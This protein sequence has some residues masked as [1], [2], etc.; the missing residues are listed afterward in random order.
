MI[1]SFS[2]SCTVLWYISYLFSILFCV[3][4]VSI[5]SFIN[6]F[7]H[8][9]L[10]LCSCTLASVSVAVFHFSCM[11]L[12][13]NLRLFLL[14]VSVAVYHFIVY[15]FVLQSSFDFCDCF[16]LITISCY[17]VCRYMYKKCSLIYK[18][19]LQNYIN[20]SKSLTV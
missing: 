8:S 10:L 19:V 2:L 9:T 20:Y 11:T 17:I 14:I 7:G 4:L 12:F 5:F 6:C 15:D 3:V 1:Y 16:D 13:C 18:I